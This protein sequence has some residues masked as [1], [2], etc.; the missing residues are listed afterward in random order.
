MSRKATATVRLT[1][2]ELWSAWRALD[3]IWETEKNEA[4]R[5]ARYKLSEAYTRLRAKDDGTKRFE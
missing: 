3:G 2:Q 1:L 4:D 5:S